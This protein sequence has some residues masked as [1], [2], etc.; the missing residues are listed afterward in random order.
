MRVSRQIFIEIFRRPFRSILMFLTVFIMVG[1]TVFG[2]FLQSIEGNISQ[3]FLAK[4][5]CYVGVQIDA[6]SE[7]SDWAGLL[8]KI[9]VLKHVNGYNSI[10]RALKCEPVNFT[11]VDYDGN[12]MPDG[13]S[14]VYLMGGC[15]TG[16][17]DFFRNDDMKL[18]EGE[19]PSDKHG[20]VA[21][22][23]NML[24][25]NGLHIGDTI[26]LS[27]GEY[28]Y[29]MRIIGVYETAVIPKIESN[30][31]GFYDET[32]SSYIFCDYDSYM[33]FN[34][35]SVL[36]MLKFFV[37]DYHELDAVCGEIEKIVGDA[38]EYALVVNGLESELENTGSLIP[39][40][41]KAS[42]MVVGFNYIC[43]AVVLGLMMV[44]WLKSHAQMIM[45]Y[46]ILGYNEL[47]IILRIVS[48]IIIIELF[49][50]GISY[51]VMS[52]ILKSTGAK[53][54][55]KLIITSGNRTVLMN[56]NHRFGGIEALGHFDGGT[57]LFYVLILIFISIAMAVGVG[58]YMSRMKIWQ[59]KKM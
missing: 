40:L 39:F 43:C 24:D 16:Y 11:N 42:G 23:K 33:Q 27:Y 52:I 15:D 12:I 55:E 22:D 37:D 3:A 34:K 21:V 59:L 29:S 35:T 31:Q 49:A 30:M 7:L 56:F 46:K 54:L 6:F 36:N 25:K 28:Q 58:I 4:T 44:L 20:G 19:M 5:G 47:K 13:V 38:G 9:L 2:S 26:T 32:T 17:I 53:F 10:G 45:I 50:G 1:F 14:Q 48:E 51:L 41:K 57:A 18:I 8:E